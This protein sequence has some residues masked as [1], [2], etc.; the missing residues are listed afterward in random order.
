MM[1]SSVG[2][3]A[4]PEAGR[5]ARRLTGLAPPVVRQN[6]V[7]AVARILTGLAAAGTRLVYFMREPTE[8]VPEGLRV[9]RAARRGGCA[10]KL[11]I[12]P[13]PVLPA[14]DAAGTA[15][16]A[17]EMERRGVACVVTLGGDGTNRAVVTGWPGSVVLPLPGG[18]NNA[19]SSPI[20]PTLAGFAA[21]LYASCPETC[22]S[23]ARRVPY[24]QVW[25]DSTPS[26]IG[27]I[28]VALVRGWRGA[29]AFWDPHSLV[30]AVIARS[31]ISL[32]GLAGLAGVLS[33]GQEVSCPVHIRFGTPGCSVIALLNPGQ[34]NQVPFRD[35][36]VLQ[37]G[38]RV[39]FGVEESAAAALVLVLDGERMI[40]V[41]IQQRVEV[42]I[43]DG[44]PR[45]I[46]AAGLLR[47]RAA[48][49]LLTTV[50]GDTTPYAAAIVRASPASAGI[51]QGYS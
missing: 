14:T 42:T 24:L 49:G 6:R 11:E 17:A 3:I 8:I 13:I 20:E 47:V 9:A 32:V 28:D 25:I 31:D 44:G 50:P 2:L 4:N 33:S 29:R 18:T 27:L 10:D 12:K 26:L 7:N 23:F 46:D 5:D 37:F 16:A 36:R 21:G 38:E 19:F 41:G 40:Q 22:S 48:E 43:L 1:R 39:V 35:W 30:E 15:A 51:R 45:V 34:I